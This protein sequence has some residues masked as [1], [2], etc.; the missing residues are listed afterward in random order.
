MR[1]RRSAEQVPRITTAP[2][3]LADDLARRQRRYLVQMG[4]RV[5]CFL[6]AV[7]TWGHVPLAVSVIMIV[8]AVVLPYVA[9]LLA[10]AG[11]EH[12]DVDTSLLDPRQIDPGPRG[13]EN[14]GG[15]R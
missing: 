8:A 1:R 13:P 7:F 15:G 3:A 2:E 10:N 14:P 9:V 12:R 4:I 11:R 5:V 6:A